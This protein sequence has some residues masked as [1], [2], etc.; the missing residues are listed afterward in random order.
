[1]ADALRNEPG[2]EVELVDGN[3]GELTVSVGGQE[4]ARKAESLPPVDAVLAAVRTAGGVA[5]G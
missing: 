3:K 5:V 4:V 1:V 2:L